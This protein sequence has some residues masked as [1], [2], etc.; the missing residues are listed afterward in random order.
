MRSIVKKAILF[1]HET[2]YRD[3]VIYEYQIIPEILSSRGHEVF[4]IEYPSTWKKNSLLDF[5][6]LKPKIVANVKKA[7][8]KKG[9][10]LITPGLVKIPIISR[11]S[12]F[13]IHFFTIP[14]V[15]NKYRIDN[16]ILYSAPTNGL[17]TIFW[18]KIFG[19]PIHF[20]LLDVLHQLVPNKILS[21]PT[22]MIEKIVYKYSNSITAIT[23]MLTKY[24]QDM[25]GR[26][27]N[28]TYL[29]SAADA[30]LFKPAAKNKKLLKQLGFSSKDII[31]I[32]AGTLYN[33]SGLD[34]L[35]EYFPHLLKKYPHL[36][37]L[38]C[39]HGEQQDLL[40]EIIK[41]HQLQDKVIMAGFIKYENLADYIN[42][43]DIGINP[44]KVNKIT[45]IIFP[46]KIYQYLACGKPVIATP[47]QG[48]IDIFPINSTKHGIHYLN[49][50]KDYNQLIKDAVA[51]K[52]FIDINPSLQQITS[53]IYDNLIPGDK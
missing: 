36:K 40:A 35:I 12:A 53:S 6:W 39:G 50:P 27:K 24:A 45:N 49:N 16:I 38:I 22:F 51:N 29:P 25:A 48:V 19:I 30:D 18:A 7:D 28:I 17:Q 15:I 4:V 9:I 43:A 23:P 10:T 37:L 44:F 14:W 46:G 20:R 47:L 3:K 1:V 31:L 42:L 34:T 11:F 32:F 26:T 52:S 8:K 5:G 33:F 13:I 2:E 21:M 41:R